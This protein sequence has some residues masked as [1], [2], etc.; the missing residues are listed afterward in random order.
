VAPPQAYDRLNA[1]SD[2]EVRFVNRSEMC[3]MSDS[4]QPLLADLGLAKLLGLEG[5]NR[6]GAVMGTW[7]YM[8]PEQVRDPAR[9]DGCADVYS[10]MQRTCTTVP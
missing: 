5:P 2:K 6:T 9:V 7:V 4:S 8:A 1:E 3:W 10:L